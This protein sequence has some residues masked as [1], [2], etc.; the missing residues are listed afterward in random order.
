MGKILFTA[1]AALLFYGGAFAG[2]S[3][4]TAEGMGLSRS[5][6]LKD[7][8]RNALEKAYGTSVFTD[9]VMINNKVAAD[10]TASYSSGYIKSYEL[11]SEK[12][13]PPYVYIVIRAKVAGGASLGAE[14]R[15]GD[16][17][18][19]IG[20]AKEL[21][22]NRADNLKSLKNILYKGLPAYLD[23]FDKCIKFRLDNISLSEYFSADIT[24]ET[25]T[26]CFK[27]SAD[28][29][30]LFL[31]GLGFPAETADKNG[32]EILTVS[33][34]D[35]YSYDVLL[36]ALKKYL[37]DSGG[38]NIMLSF[39]DADGK[40][41][42]SY[43]IC[44]YRGV[45]YLAGEIVISILD[46]KDFYF[47][48]S[49]YIGEAVIKRAASAGAEISKMPDKGYKIGVVTVSSAV[50]FEGLK[51]L[52]VSKGSPAEKAGI[53]PG[54][55]IISVNGVPAGTPE[56][57]AGIING[58][59]VSEIALELYRKGVKIRASLIPQRVRFKKE[60]EI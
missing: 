37:A 24:A 41:I 44:S 6:A 52:S 15:D 14:E 27:K 26:A 38:K 31:N 9:S 18:I 34:R 32:K 20:S 17:F 57:A 36:D 39:K 28:S 47:P 58:Q 16:G 54:D 22:Q 1:A 5:L 35:K 13:E 42:D 49:G 2:I 30:A 4:I 3:E 51:V 12:A 29:L 45:V 60:W 56:E 33:K 8:F 40:Y 55:R 10:R 23:V 48:F 19:G 53:I 11:V 7:A 50:S 43:K 46:Y 59:G 21:E 25:D